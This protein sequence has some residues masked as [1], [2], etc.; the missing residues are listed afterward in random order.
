MF[1][2]KKKQQQ[3]KNNSAFNPNGDR[4]K[5]KPFVPLGDNKTLI[6]MRKASSYTIEKYGKKRLVHKHLASGKSDYRILDEHKHMIFKTEDY[7]EAH[8]ELIKVVHTNGETINWIFGLSGSEWDDVSVHSFRGTK[9][10][11]KEM[12]VKL[13]KEDMKEDTYDYGTEDVSEVKELPDGR[14][15]AGT[16]FRNCHNDYT[17]TPV[18][19]MSGINEYLEDYELEEV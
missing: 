8:A 11:A 3:Q 7:E 2:S 5:G 17:A 16:T 6:Q 15:Y 19:S 4:L 10:E 14:L 1:G 12:L 18:N 13:V 9:Q